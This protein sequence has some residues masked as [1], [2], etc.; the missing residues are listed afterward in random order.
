[1]IIVKSKTDLEKMRLAG[2]AAAHALIF[3]GEQVKPGV[4]THAIERAIIRFLKDCGATPSFL[5]YEGFTGAACISVN[6]EIIHGIPSRSRILREG[7]IVSIDIGAK[8]NGFHGDTA[9][10]F[11]VGEVSDEAKKLMQVTKETL[12]ASIAQ[13]V[14]GNRVGDISNKIQTYAESN[15]YYVNRVFCGHG[16]GRALHEDPEIPNYGKAGKGTRLTNG[17]TLAIEPMVGATASKCKILSDG[18]TVVS[19]DGSL[20]AHYEHTIVVS[21]ETPL[22]LTDSPLWV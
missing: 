12:Y 18:W 10:T 15:G 17:M 7:D 4:T 22:I 16:I 6:E 14:V 21:G 20:S 5:H 3:A 1:M 11:A 19:L 9:A 2:K 8:V 13:A